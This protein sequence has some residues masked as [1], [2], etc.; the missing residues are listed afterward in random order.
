MYNRRRARKALACDCY[1]AEIGKLK[2]AFGGK[3]EITFD[4]KQVQNGKLLIIRVRNTG[5]TEIRKADFQ[6]PSLGFVFP[7]AVSVL[8]AEITERDPID[9]D[10]ACNQLLLAGDEKNGSASSPSIEVPATLFNSGDS[11]S[12]AA[13]VTGFTDKFEIRGRIAGIRTI[14]QTFLS[15]PSTSE[16][17]SRKNA[18][19]ALILSAFVPG[20]GQFYNGDVLKG[21][22]LLG[23]YVISIFLLLVPVFGLLVTL[24]V[25]AWAAADAYKSAAR[26]RPRH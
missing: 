18:M 10:V 4:G 20:A 21:S 16:G 19:V 25:W 23:L 14:K 3:L 11:F 7:P 1:T 22:I 12:I 5:G 9:L 17:L 24:V 13:L 6:S 2:H 15:E 26:M 8:T